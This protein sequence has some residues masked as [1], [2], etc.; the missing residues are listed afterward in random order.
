MPI[1]RHALLVGIN[2]YPLVPNADLAGCLADVELMRMVLVERFAFADADIAEL[3]DGEA[4]RD[5]IRAALDDLTERIGKND[6]AVLFYAGHGSRVADPR[7]P[8][9]FLESIVPYDS[10]RPANDADASGDEG[11]PNRDLLDV[12]IDAWTQRLNAKTPHVTLIFDCCHSGGVSRM[13]GDAVREVAA[14][15]RPI[16]LPDLP[17]TGPP[18]G[19]AGWLRGGRRA[20]VVAACAAEEYADEHR[21]LENRRLLRHG[22]LSFFLGRTLLELG[23]APDGRPPTWCPPT[24]RQVLSTLAPRLGAAHPRQHPVLEGEIDARIFGAES[25]APRRHL[26]V[27]RIA[28]GR[29]SLDGGAA[30]GVTVDSVWSLVPP[31]ATDAV[32]EL[33]VDEVG[34]TRC[35]GTLTPTG[36]MGRADSVE[37]GAWAMPREQPVPA[38]VLRVAAAAGTARDEVAALCDLSPA[39]EP[40]EDAQDFVDADL[41]ARLDSNL[42]DCPPTWTILDRS[43]SVAVRARPRD[44]LRELVADLE[45]LARA[46]ALT[47][48]EPESPSGPLDGLLRLEILR[49]GR[50]VDAETIFHEGDRAEIVVNSD[51]DTELWIS[52]LQIG[53][54]HAV[55]LLLPRAGHPSFRLGGFPLPPRASLRLAAD[56]YR[57]DPRFRGGV[58]GGFELRLPE[59]FPWSDPSN[60]DAEATLFLKLLASTEPVD[61]TFVE[62]PSARPAVSHPLARRLAIACGPPGGRASVAARNTDGESAW[63]VV[64]A[65]VR[66][67]RGGGAP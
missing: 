1:R 58:Q 52:L 55:E 34:A 8:G 50:A 59:G 3:R 60:R 63:T 14:D 23:N 61:F 65:A 30:H 42:D 27:S 16:E 43:G 62:Q 44:A 53:T 56:Y 47:A 46:R 32:A 19:D 28:D 18:R 39:L 54:D 35:A 26:R 48:L 6:V 33:R 24:W 41:E 22:A 20:T 10:G 2:R 31:T 13:F 15:L 64:T 21:T 37:I 66:V 11:P 5:G 4:T 12:E 51:V 49:D 7:R 40:V 25:L 29:A 67:R 9:F 57:L 36:A 38:S 17:T 45:R